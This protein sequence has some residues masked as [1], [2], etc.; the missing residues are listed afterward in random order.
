MTHHLPTAAD[1]RRAATRIAGHVHLTP[2]F[3]CRAID[4]RAGA[5]VFSKAENLQKV[6]AFKARGA[7]NAVLSLDSRSLARGIATHSSGNHGQAVAYAAQVVGAEAVVV[8][9]D[10]APTV[11]VDAVRGY[12]ARVVMCRQ[13]EREAV[14]ADLVEANAYTVVHPFD[15]ARVIA[16]QGTAVLEL[17]S[18]VHDLDV[19]VT[20][21]GGGGLLSGSTLAASTLGIPTIGAEPVV[22]DDAARSLESR[23]RLGPTGNL[24]VGDGLL[25]GIGELAFEI[26]SAAGTRI[27]TVT[28]DEIMEATRFVVARTKYLIEPS[29]GTAYAAIFAN[30]DLFRGSRVGVVVSG[31]NVDL[32]MIGTWPRTP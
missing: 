11:K 4:T 2:V 12:G 14:L 20:P 23:T 30:P 3:T 5:E 18:Q 9:P 26:L 27:L 24:S 15:D 22:V 21:I 31:G 28:E 10:H 7:L 25:T 32:A 19:V 8:M 1:V 16:G 6:G 17:L 29:A 13:S